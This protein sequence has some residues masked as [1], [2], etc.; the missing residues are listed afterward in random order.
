M[1]KGSGLGGLKAQLYL[2]KTKKIVEVKTCKY[3]G[4]TTKNKATA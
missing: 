4:T 3:Y 1:L 2:K